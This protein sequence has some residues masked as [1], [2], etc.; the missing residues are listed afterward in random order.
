[1]SERGVTLLELLVV[2]GLFLLL[3]TLSF[4][5]LDRSA[6]Y[7]SSVMA[8]ADVA[9]QLSRACQRL[10]TDLAR[11]R[12][13]ETAVADTPAYLA[14][15]GSD[16]SAIWFLSAQDP[17]TGVFAKQPDAEPFWQKNVLYYLVTPS[18]HQN[19]FGVDC[20]G[21][22]TADGFD[23]GCPHKVLVRKVIDSGVVT[24]PTG[25]LANRETLLPGVTSYLTRPAGLDVS[26][27]TGESGLVESRIVARNL[28]GFRVQRAPDPAFDTEIQVTVIA[29]KTAN[30]KSIQ[31][32]VAPLSQ[33]GLVGQRSFSVFPAN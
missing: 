25:A 14:A 23:D 11:S 32:G 33:T 28:V 27:F 7:G 8:Q 21:R 15:G 5:A 29:A 10:R 9:D 18:D 3:G 22:R 2:G 12:F 30:L 4:L 26:A 1:M 31:I 24:E 17:T 19:S 20:Q 16:G 6:T 13:D